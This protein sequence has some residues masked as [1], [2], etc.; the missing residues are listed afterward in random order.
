MVILDI[1]FRFSN[2]EF[3]ILNLEFRI[4]NLEWS[5]WAFVVCNTNMCMCQLY[6]KYHSCWAY[7]TKLF[8]P[9]NLKFI[10]QIKPVINIYMTILYIFCYHLTLFYRKQSALYIPNIHTMHTTI[11][12]C[13]IAL[14]YT[15][16]KNIISIIR[17]FSYAQKIKCHRR[18]KLEKTTLYSNKR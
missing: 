7:R 1:E 14:A 12:M 18:T 6:I 10:K 17:K 2:F 9:A 5:F 3:Q 11:Y 15:L 13:K 4:L 16:L 8:F